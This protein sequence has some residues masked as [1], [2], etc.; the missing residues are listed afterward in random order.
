MNPVAVLY[1]WFRENRELFISSGAELEFRDSGHGSGY[2]RLETDFYMMELCAWDHAS[3]LDIQ[4]I[5]VKSE[6][7]S[8]PHTG[9]CESI[10]EFKNHLNEFLV[11]FKCEVGENA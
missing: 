10:N 2:V 11:W 8:F 3:C 1:S 9:D 6:E 4:I 7:S 5:E